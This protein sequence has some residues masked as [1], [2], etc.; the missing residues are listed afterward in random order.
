[1]LFLGAEFYDW[2]FI[3]TIWVAISDWWIIPGTEDLLDTWH[4]T[5]VKR[6]KMLKLVVYG[7]PIAA[8]VGGLC[9]LAGLLAG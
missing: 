4:S 8:I 5:K 1:M 9:W 6:W 3:D 2:L 7:L